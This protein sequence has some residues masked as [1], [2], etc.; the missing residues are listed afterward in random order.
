MISKNVKLPPSPPH[1]NNLNILKLKVPRMSTKTNK[2]RKI[3]SPDL[4]WNWSR[5]WAKLILRSTGAVTLHLSYVLSRSCSVEIL[6]FLSGDTGVVMAAHQAETGLEDKEC[7]E[8]EHGERT[9]RVSDWSGRHEPLYT[10]GQIC[11]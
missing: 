8:A 6:V 2:R 11:L 5:S 10:V 4:N 1:T 3:L 9:F 7:V